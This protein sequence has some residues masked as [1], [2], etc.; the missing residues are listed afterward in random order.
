[1]IG[2]LGWLAAGVVLGVTGYRRASR[3]ARSVRPAGIAARWSWPASGPDAPAARLSRPPG[4][5]PP[6][7]SAGWDRSPATCGTAWSFTWIVIPGRQA[8][9][10]KAVTS[11]DSK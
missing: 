2:R 6:P 5:A 1:M 3:L 8:I 9:T 10:S 11:M 7:A 4:A